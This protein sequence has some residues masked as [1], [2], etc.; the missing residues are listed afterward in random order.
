MISYN[1]RLFK[2]PV[3]SGAL[4]ADNVFALIRAGRLS[5]LKES[6]PMQNLAHITRVGPPTSRPATD[7][8]PTGDPFVIE[9]ERGHGPEFLSLSPSAAVALWKELGIYMRRHGVEAGN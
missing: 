5:A 9:I 7:L 8:A 3:G 6:Y 4:L 1:H 2:T